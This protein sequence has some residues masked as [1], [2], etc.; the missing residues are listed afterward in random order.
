MKKIISL[1]LVITLVLAF[2]S[3]SASDKD[4]KENNSTLDI[5]CTIFPQY[6][7]VRTITKGVKGVNITMLLAPGNESHSY[8]A[9]MSDMSKIQNADLFIYVGGESDEWVDGVLKTVDT[10]NVKAVALTDLVKLLEE[11]DKGIVSTEEEEEEEG[12]TDEHVW[13]SLK[14]AQTIVNS[15]C[16]TICELDK[17]NESAYKAN[18]E[19]YC[20]ELAKLDG[21]FAE[22]VKT[23][24]TKKLVLA[25]RNPF[26]YM[27]NDYGIEATAAFS[28]CSANTEI[29]LGVQNELI[30][31]IKENKLKTVF[32]IELNSSDYADAICKQ[33]GAEKAVLNSCHNVTEEDFKSGKTYLELMTENLKTLRGALN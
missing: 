9:S 13:T 6:D 28:G 27:F 19:K 4:K 3:C 11:S 29:S 22:M 33:T 32:V 15:L 14:N 10:S 17:A 7:F 26:L 8:E 1:L 18:A 5:V 24:A 31:A 23:A 20:A 12:A 21:E 2:A 25:D 16:N 30:K